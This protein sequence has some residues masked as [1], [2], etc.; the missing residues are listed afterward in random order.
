MLCVEVGADRAQDEANPSKEVSKLNHCC[1]WKISTF[2][3][4][5]LSSVFMNGEVVEMMFAEGPV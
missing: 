3:M 4:L 1:D 5:S 2:R